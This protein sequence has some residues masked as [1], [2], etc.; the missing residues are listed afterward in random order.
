MRHS[1]T[2]LL[3][4]VTVK[5]GGKIFTVSIVDTGGSEMSEY[6]DYSRRR[7]EAEEEP[8]RQRDSES[9]RMRDQREMRDYDY[10]GTPDYRSQGNRYS[11]DDMDTGQGRRNPRDYYYAGS[12]QTG[13][14]TNR[15]GGIYNR[16][17][18]YGFSGRGSSRG[19]NFSGYDFN[20][21]DPGSER[22]GSRSPVG[23]YGQG[24][25]QGSWTQGGAGIQ[26]GG[27]TR[28]QHSGRGPQ[29]YKRSR[30][31]IMEDVCDILTE[32]GGIDASNMNVQVDE[33]GEVTLEGRVTSR[34]EKRMAEDAIEN[35]PGVTQV[36]NRLR[37]QTDGN[38]QST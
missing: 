22:F 25:M 20:D 17:D 36:H 3:L 38:R 11:D 5:S 13:A 30:D 33:N 31:R 35:V 7:R 29:G 27:L 23:Q 32:H 26:T 16:E 10:Y 34:V 24:G 21:Y 6:S 9:R 37:V 19:D 2:R 14:E 4:S 15:S 1:L 8:Y 28:G 18:D 12:Q